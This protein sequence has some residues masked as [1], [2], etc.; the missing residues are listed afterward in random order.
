MNL[1]VLK[2]TS[3]THF[4]FSDL[5]TGVFYQQ[6]KLANLAASCVDDMMTSL[7]TAHLSSVT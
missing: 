2:V 7:E 5:A 4:F 6:T 1:S 3:V